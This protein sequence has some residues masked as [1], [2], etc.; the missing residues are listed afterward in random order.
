ML[1][2]NFWNGYYGNDVEKSKTFYSVNINYYS[3]Y[4]KLERSSLIYQYLTQQSHFWIFTQKILSQCVLEIS[5]GLCS[6]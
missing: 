3:H 5:A 2:H 1:P 4:E 6:F